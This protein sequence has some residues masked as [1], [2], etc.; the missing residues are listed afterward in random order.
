[1]QR[2]RIL[3]VALATT[4]AALPAASQQG[5]AP[6]TN[7]YIDVA[8]HNMVGM[9]DM[10]AM[11]GMG[12]L[13]ARR[14][15]GGRDAA[16]P[17]YPTTRTGGMSGQYLDMALFNA[18]K[19]GLPVQDQ[20]PAGLQL[21]SSLKLIP[22]DPSTSRHDK[23]LGEVPDVEVRISEYWGCGASIRPGQPKVAS[24]K[25]KGGT[26][27]PRRGMRGMDFEATGSLSRGLFAPDHDID[28][29]PGFV[30][31]PNREDGQRV[32]DGA[33]LAGDHQ[34]TG[35]GIPASMQFQVQQAADFMPR[36]M[37]RTQGQPTDTVQLS[38]PGVDRA[39]AYFITGMKMHMASEHSF[40]LVIWS[41][42][43][44][45][46][47]GSALHAY[48]GGSTVEKWLRQKVLLP[49]DSSQCMIPKG[50]FAGTGGRDDAM[51]AMLMMTA[52]GPES[53]ISYPPR[54]ANPRQPWNPEWSVRLRAKSTAMALL[55]VDFGGMG[56]PMGNDGQ[57]QP[58][59]KHPVMKG[60][61]HGIL[62]GG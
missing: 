30:Y 11:G 23:A 28:L 2:R 49:A 19:P 15:G 12:G 27:D 6:P 22:V 47:A 39:R 35:E 60:L 53:W 50:I 43:E 36:L 21:G 62:G 57:P 25:V 1:M 26:V 54:P 52:Y 7:L 20:I 31:W 9:P 41:S 61:L 18:L 45:P 58:K 55:G 37:L 48:L 44:V 3:A 32:P 42:S 34:I 24:F 13:M 33:H 5:K 14:M 56:Q 51:P 29:K 46:G 40:D 16:K 17:V 59:E 38:W 4:L 8:T 10:S